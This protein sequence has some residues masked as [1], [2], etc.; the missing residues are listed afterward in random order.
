MY[1]FTTSSGKHL[2]GNNPAHIA[3]L[4]FKLITSSKVSDGLSIEFDRDRNRGQGELTDNKNRKEA[5]KL[6]LCLGMYSILLNIK[7]N[8]LWF[9]IKTDNNKKKR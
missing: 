7:K 3:S 5:I 9:R 6:E 1:K 2:E 4:K 8:Y